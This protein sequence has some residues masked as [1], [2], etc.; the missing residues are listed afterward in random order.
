MAKALIVIDVQNGFVTK[1]SQH[2]VPKI[3]RLLES[4]KF[5]TVIFTKFVNAPNSPFRKIKKWYKVAAPPE[6]DIVNDLKQFA[7]TIFQKNVYSAFTPEFEHFLKENKIS[8]LYFVGIDT[9]CCVLKT[10]IDAFEKG[11]EPFLLADYCAS[12]ES[13]QYHTIGLKLFGR[14]V[15]PNNIIK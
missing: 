1:S 11:Y 5:D 12:H 3:K 6:T 10:A 14:L 13:R 8:Q 9:E 4:K 2:V 15:S 7:S